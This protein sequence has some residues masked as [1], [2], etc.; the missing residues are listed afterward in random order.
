MDKIQYSHIRS[1]DS[2]LSLL[3]KFDS[4]FGSKTAKKKWALAQWKTIPVLQV[5]PDIEAICWYYKTK[6]NQSTT[7]K[8]LEEGT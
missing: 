2:V 8:L 6:Q 7:V 4:D 1:C 3:R 5:T